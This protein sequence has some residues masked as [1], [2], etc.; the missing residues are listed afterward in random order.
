MSISCETDIKLTLQDKLKVFSGPGDGLVPSGCKPLP[1]PV[2]I[3]LW[4]SIWHHQEPMS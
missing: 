3:L 4:A 2:M 1:V